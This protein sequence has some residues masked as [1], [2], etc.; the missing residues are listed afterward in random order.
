[1]PDGSGGYTTVLTQTGTV[2]AISPTSITERSDDGY[3]QTYVVPSTP[4]AT[5]PF[6]V[7]DPV[8]IAR[9]ARPTPRR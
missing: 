3:T 4:G 7:D 6:A 9:P 8:T 5:P 1:M 2:T